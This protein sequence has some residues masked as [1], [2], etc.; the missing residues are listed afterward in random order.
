METFKEA[1]YKEVGESEEARNLNIG[2][3]SYHHKLGK[4]SQKLDW[5]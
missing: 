4:G 3:D 1:V 2:V 5:L